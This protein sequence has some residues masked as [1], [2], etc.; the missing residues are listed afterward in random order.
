MACRETCGR[1]QR[2]TVEREQQT[3]AVPPEQMPTEARGRKQSA[4]GRS[5]RG[6]REV[7]AREGTSMCRGSQGE[8]QRGMSEVPTERARRPA[9]AHMRARRARRAGARRSSG[10]RRHEARTCGLPEGSCATKRFC[11]S[12]MRACWS[13]TAVAAV[14]KQRSYAS[15]V[16]A[17]AFSRSSKDVLRSALR[18]TSSSV[19]LSRACCRVRTFSAPATSSRVRARQCQHRERRGARSGARSGA[20]TV[21]HLCTSQTARPC[22]LLA[23]QGPPLLA[24]WL[25]ASSPG[26]HRAAQTAAEV[27][28]RS[29]SSRSSVPSTPSGCLG[30]GC[31]QRT[32]RT[33]RAPKTR[34]AAAACS[35]RPG[36]VRE[37]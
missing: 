25:K 13:S 34:R 18:R 33:T 3:L 2:Q 6:R 11:T 32:S 27:R 10:A 28:G 1:E 14:L 19:S 35:R 23:P 29:A 15:R 8:G 5:A 16:A 7:G 22:L 24:L 31:P 9:Q 12:V 20:H 21:R 17:V 30:R 26:L 4:H 36:V 37:P